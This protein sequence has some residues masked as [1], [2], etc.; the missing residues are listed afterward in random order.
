MLVPGMALRPRR[1]VATIHAPVSR[2]AHHDDYACACRSLARMTARS[3]GLFDTASVVGLHGDHYVVDALKRHDPAAFRDTLIITTARSPIQRAVSLYHHF[4]GSPLQ[5]GL[6]GRSLSAFLESGFVEGRAYS[7]HNYLTRMLGSGDLC[8]AHC[9]AGASQHPQQRN[10]SSNSDECA[11]WNRKLKSAV[12]FLEHEVCAVFVTERAN[13]SLAYLAHV[14]SVPLG[15][16]LPPLRV[17]NAFEN[18]TVKSAML[19]SAAAASL[20]LDDGMIR[21]EDGSGWSVSSDLKKVFE[22]H[23]AADVALYGLVNRRLDRQT[24]AMEQGDGRA[25]S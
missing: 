1:T 12:Q 4:K 3:G 13:A 24:A 5:A 14:L 6:P 11:S 22:A 19:A 9:S 10:V 8:S 17:V 21:L 15:R 7:M 16:A 20:K 23:N 25:A 2:R 18:R